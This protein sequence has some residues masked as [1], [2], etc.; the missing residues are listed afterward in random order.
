MS[1]LRIYDPPECTAEGEPLDWERCRTCTDGR[2]PTPADQ[3]GPPET[4]CDKCEGFGSLRAAALASR[5]RQRSYE[6]A[7]E[8]G[9]IRR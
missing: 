9:H 6:L 4:I 2:R 5:L 7:V 1:I 3:P 8:R